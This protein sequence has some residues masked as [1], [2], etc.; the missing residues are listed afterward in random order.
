MLKDRAL[1]APPVARTLNDR[2]VGQIRKQIV[3]GRLNPGERLVELRLAEQ[4]R[5]SRSTVREALQR[6]KAE[7]LVEISPYAGSRVAQLKSADA[8]QI[9]ELH[10]LL[11]SHSMRQ[12]ALP[13]ADPV[14]AHLDQ[15]VRRMGDLQLPEEIDQFI[16]LDHAFH[17]SLVAATGQALVLEVWNGLSSLLGVVIALSYRQIGLDA[18]AIAERHRVI[19]EAVGQ[20]SREVA[21]AVIAD[22]YRS[23]ESRLGEAAWADAAGG[24]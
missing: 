22:H 15:L 16:D 4:L 21:A 1:L 8:V 7:H 6:L 17:G 10:A 23:L 13:V 11:A 12:L 5:V 3:L 19:V 14:R 18:A 20:P 24:G 2:V 9:C